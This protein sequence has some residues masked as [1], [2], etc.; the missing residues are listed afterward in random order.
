MFCTFVSY[1]CRS[2]ELSRLGSSL[3]PVCMLEKWTFFSP[4][5]TCPPTPQKSYLKVLTPGNL[6]C[7]LGACIAFPTNHKGSRQEKIQTNLGHCGWVAEGQTPI[8][9]CILYEIAIFI[10]GISGQLNYFLICVSTSLGWVGDR[11]L[12]TMSQV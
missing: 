10:Q 11:L 6:L 7:S 4:G 5:Y 12:G 1:T 2:T 8:P 3:P 9:N